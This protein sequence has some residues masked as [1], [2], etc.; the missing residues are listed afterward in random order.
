LAIAI[1]LT[2]LI[3]IVARFVWV[4]PA[5]YVPRW[6]VPPL[7]R[8]DPAPSWQPVFLLAFTG[9]RGV[10]SLAA[11]LAIPYALD[12]G[13]PFPQRE[14]ILFVAFGVIIATLVGQGSMLPAI[15]RWLGLNR[16]GT[17]EHLGDIE[18][19][20]AARQSA[21]HEVEQRLEKFAAERQ[22]PANV[23]EL[24][25]TRNLTRNQILPKNLGDGLELTRLSAAV[26]RELIDTERAF[27][28]QMLRDGKI[29]D[30]ARRRI[31]YELDLEEASLANRGSG[32]GGWI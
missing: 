24:L 15:V 30:E 4:F 16:L 9:V 7:A 5:I 13:Q 26:K 27:I 29:T 20:L 32:G 10:V 2:T 31:E 1:A 14:V 18:A 8:R 28:F 21:L 12:N 3:V 23:V 6:L 11:A 25:R 17:N 22:L 19:E